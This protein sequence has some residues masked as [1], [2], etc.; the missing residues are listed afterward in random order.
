M[1]TEV[2]ANFVLSQQRK[3]ALPLLRELKLG[4]G[5]FVMD[6]EWGKGRLSVGGVPPKM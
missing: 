4:G 6:P 2:F 3:L 5:S 1:T